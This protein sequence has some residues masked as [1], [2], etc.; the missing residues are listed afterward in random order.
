MIWIYLLASYLLGSIMFGFLISKIFYQVDIRGQGSGNI[1][2][3]NAGRLHGKL[4][5]V[6]IFLGDALKGA[7]V[8]LIA[9]Y[10]QF[11]EPVQLVGL[12]L[13]I[14]GHLK[15]VTL[16]FKGGKGIS[17]FIGGM[18]TF[19]PL[20]VP[21]IILTFGV[22]YPFIRSFTLA[23]LG[24]FLIIPLFLFYRNN[25]VLSFIIEI[26]LVVM[27]LLAHTENVKERLK[28]NG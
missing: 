14:T 16:K 11:A 24:T 8:V 9:R 3:R 28:R 17:T 7:V 13:A 10:F 22:L 4:A 15:P 2:A 6:V 26:A 20:L 25:D 23:G 5:F 27:I 12:A 18:L 19:E 1:G 21:V